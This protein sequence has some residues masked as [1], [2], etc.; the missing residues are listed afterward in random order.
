[1]KTVRVLGL[2][3]CSRCNSLKGE[4]YYNNIPF[5]F[6]DVDRQTRIADFVEDLL[7]TDLYPIAIVEDSGSVCYVYSPDTS[8]DLGKKNIDE[9]VSKIGVFTLED[10]VREIKIL[11]I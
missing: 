4:L 8:F 10:M 11:L 2:G 6:I 5:S 3:S 9:R 7:Q 1:M